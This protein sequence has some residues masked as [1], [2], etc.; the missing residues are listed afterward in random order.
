M[1]VSAVPQAIALSKAQGSG[2]AQNKAAPTAAASPV[3]SSSISLPASSS[4]QPSLTSEP[5]TL[6]TPLPAT[7]DAINLLS[8]LPPGP[9]YNNLER[10]ALLAI[11]EGAILV[12]EQRS[13]QLLKVKLQEEINARADQAKDVPDPGRDFCAVFCG[14]CS[15]LPAT[16]ETALLNRLADA[17]ARWCSC[18][19]VLLV[20]DLLG[21]RS[22]FITVL[23][24]AECDRAIRALEAQLMGAVKVRVQDHD[25][26][27]L[28]C[29]PFAGRP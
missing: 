4:A 29:R 28:I 27:S 13:L 11:S 16:L 10:K 3:I 5:S 20:V 8:S 18:L 19:C 26:G 14:G 23:S 2:R 7:S 12:E 15:G 21:L 9:S 6:P 17:P 24:A 1:P 25:L 22:C